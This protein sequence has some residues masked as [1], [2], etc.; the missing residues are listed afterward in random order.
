M[1]ALAGKDQMSY[2]G[3]GGSFSSIQD[4][5]GQQ[6]I[7]K[8]GSKIDSIQIGNAKYGGGGGSPTASFK[9]PQDGKFKLLRLCTNH[10]VVGY[11]KLE[12]AGIVYESG[13]ITGDG[14]IDFG[15]GV[16]VSFAGT[17]SGTYIDMIL[18]STSY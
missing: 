1:K 3:H 6:V 10:D 17:S 18:F 13:E 2:G 11:I 5:G 8:S 4:T 15:S 14:D 9:L 12:C 16:E 7:I